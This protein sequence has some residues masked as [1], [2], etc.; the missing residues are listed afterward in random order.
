MY[1]HENGTFAYI[2]GI[3]HEYGVNGNYIIV[4]D[5]IF[6]NYLFATGSDAGLDATEGNKELKI[7]DDGSITDSKPQET[8]ETTLVLKKSSTSIK[9]DDYDINYMINN[10]YISNNASDEE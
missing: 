1:L 10:F 2:T 9:D 8:S 6:L 5:T 4:D 3:D 7:N